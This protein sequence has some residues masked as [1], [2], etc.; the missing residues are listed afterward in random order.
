VSERV[1]QTI[2]LCEDRVQ[3]SLV[4][5]YIGC[6]GLNTNEPCLHPIIASEQV[7][8]GNVGWVLREFPRQLEACR[9]RQTRAKTL[10]I[11]VADADSLGV[12][13]RYRDLTRALQG[14]G[15]EA[16][17]P[18][19]PIVVL[20]P[21]RHVETWIHTTT[22]QPTNETDDYKSDQPSKADL[23]VAAHIIHGWAHDIPEPDENCVPSLRIAL[24]EWRNIG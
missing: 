20:I 22:G 15:L 13:E 9:K 11:V 6:C 4:R 19:D 16:I 14:A 5:L 12:D 7:R 24:P 10:L 3:A 17:A 23:R 8:G 2:L 1:S 18:S 21:K